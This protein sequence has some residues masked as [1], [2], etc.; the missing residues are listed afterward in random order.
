MATFV[1]VHGA[2]T[3]GWSWKKMHPLMAE[4]GHRLI[5]PTMTGL[6]ERGHLARPDV[7]LETHIADIVAVL[8]FEDLKNVNLIGHSYGG[9][10]AT[11]VVDRAGDR[12][13]QLIYLDAM[14]PRDGECA[15]DILPEVIRAHRKV[16]ADGLVEPQPMPADTSPED[17]AWAHPRRRRQPAKTQEQKLRLQ[18]GPLTLPRHYI[19]CTHH[20]PDDRFGPFYARAKQEGW[21]TYELDSTHNPHITN[22]VVLADLLDRIAV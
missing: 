13:A 14:V 5:T 11:G 7:D 20:R 17:H 4:R 9:M 15:L 1:V 8:E 3:G 22:P 10:P 6:G 18:N 21:G 16:G 2:W 19:Y 12:I